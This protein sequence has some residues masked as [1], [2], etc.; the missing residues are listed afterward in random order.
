MNGLR[1]KLKGIGMRY[2]SDNI[3][4]TI[5]LSTKRRWG[6]T[7]LLEYI[8]DLE[9]KDKSR[10]S[11]ERRTSRSK[12]ERFKPM[13]DF[14]W[15]WPKKINRAAVE[16]A[17]ALDFM[18]E[19]NNVVLIAPQGLGKTMIAKNIVHNAVLKG[20]EALFITAA[21]LLLDLA[22]QESA[23]ALDRRLKY[24]AK[25]SCLCI[26]EIGYLSYDVRNA[27][28]L[29]RV[30]SMRYEKKSLV[31]TTN[32]RFAEWPTIFPGAACTTALIDRAVHHAAIISIDGDSYRLREAKQKTADS[33]QK[34]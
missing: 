5:A 20:H 24:Y 29:F 23:R 4:D 2:T 1:D 16:S 14:D 33:P 17:L 6:P 3:E 7:Q 28:L 32:L 30:V 21:D 8:V 34:P 18:T 15:K 12:L 27:D 11:L 22:A 31:L 10:R 9:I 26:D 19:A 13:A 25:I